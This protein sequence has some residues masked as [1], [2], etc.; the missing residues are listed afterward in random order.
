MRDERDL[1]T[2]SDFGR[3]F[4]F[5]YLML[6]YQAGPLSGLPANLATGRLISVSVMTSTLMTPSLESSPTEI[7]FEIYG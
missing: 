2:D 3:G 6:V 1:R 4:P 5:N 7:T